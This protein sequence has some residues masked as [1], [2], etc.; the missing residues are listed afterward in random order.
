MPLKTVMELMQTEHNFR[1]TCVLALLVSLSWKACLTDYT[2]TKMYKTRFKQWQLRKN[3]PST[4]QY[5]LPQR[6]N[7]ARGDLPLSCDST[8]LGPPVEKMAGQGLRNILSPDSTYASESLLNAVL[9]YSR[10]AFDHERWD[11]TALDYSNNETGQWGRELKVAAHAIGRNHDMSFGFQRLNECCARFGSISQQEDPLLI[12]SVYVGIIQLRHHASDDKV[13]QLFTKYVA[14]MANVQFGREHPLAKVLGTIQ[15][16][17]IYQASQAAQAVLRA[18]F[19]VFR[20]RTRSGNALV[21][22]TTIII[23]KDLNNM[24][25]ISVVESIDVLKS[26]IQELEIDSNNQDNTVL[27]EHYLHWTRLLF[28]ACLSAHNDYAKAEE[29]LAQIDESWRDVSTIDCATAKSECRQALIVDCHAIRAGIEETQ[30]R[31]DRAEMCL[32]KELAAAIELK[33]CL[34]L[35]R[36]LGVYDSLERFH[37]RRGNIEAAEATRQLYVDAYESYDN[38]SGLSKEELTGFSP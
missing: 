12:T 32:K 8:R 24:G 36:F 6:A 37:G 27:S 11:L 5:S 15:S 13:A 23:T 10:S 20:E 25:L 28:A 9:S 30:G 14:N 17:G 21:T 3:I 33:S 38:A 4:R 1:A 34:S 16:M 7:V 29:V 26:V 18:Q 2:R 22:Q 19:D 31:Y 35:T